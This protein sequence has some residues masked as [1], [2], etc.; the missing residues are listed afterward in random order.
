MSTVTPDAQVTRLTA[1]HWLIIVISAIGFA[2][3][4]YVLLMLP[5][6]VRPALSELLQVAPTSPLVND[7]A[8]ILF[9]IPAIAGGIFGLL[10]GYLT[11]V[12]GRRRVLVWSILL[13]A[14]SALASGFSTSVGW[15]LFW[16]CGTFVGVCVEFVA[17]VAW[18]S[19][20]FQEPKKRE[21]VIGGTQAFGSIGGVMVTGMYYLV[22]TYENSLPAVFGG[23]AAWRY[24]LMSGIIPAIPLIIIRPFLPESPIWK[25]KKAA[26]TL[27]R[28]SFG[29]LFQ[30]Q[31]RR[32]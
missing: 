27:K 31:F 2:F 21:A 22:N 20:L 7:W 29:E 30:P 10:G 26:G 16:R 17:A 23:H 32:T 1:L 6:I 3:D 4:S 5:L 11:D 25:E 24:T 19:E 15:L 18:L 28:P 12:F 9:Y 13:Y 8:G 14:F